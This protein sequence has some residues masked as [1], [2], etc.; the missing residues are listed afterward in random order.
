MLCFFYTLARRKNPKFWV[1][2]GLYCFIS[3]S[4]VV[5]LC[6]YDGAVGVVVGIGIKVKVKMYSMRTD[7][8]IL[9]FRESCFTQ[10]PACVKV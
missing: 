4:F 3:G 5:M 2:G 8:G 6:C 10:N 7:A 9:W 1:S